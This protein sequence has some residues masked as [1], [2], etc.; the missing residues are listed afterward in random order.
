MKLSIVVLLI[1]TAAGMAAAQPYADCDMNTY[2][3]SL[4]LAKDRAEMHTLIK[5][6]HRNQL[7][8]TSSAPDVW[9][10]LIALDSDGE[11]FRLFLVCR[12]VQKCRLY[13]NQVY[14]HHFN[15]HFLFFINLCVLVYRLVLEYYLVN[16]C[17]AMSELDQ[18][19]TLFR[20]AVVA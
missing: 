4:S 19:L 14:V 10:A 8:Y 5:N 12:C 1:A 6:T 11:L 13:Q 16:V 17:H 18:F 2:Y 3:S 20:W 15:V 7:P 9:D